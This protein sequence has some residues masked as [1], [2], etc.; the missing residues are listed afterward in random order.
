LALTIFVPSEALAEDFECNGTFAGGTFDNVVVPSG[1]TCILK[2]ATVEGNI[3]V[4]P[5]GALGLEGGIVGGNVESDTARS[6]Y[7]D[8]GL[9]LPG[10]QFGCRSIGVP[11]MIDGNVLIKKTFERPIFDNWICSAKIGGELHL[12]ENEEPF[13]VGD[14]EPTLSTAPGSMWCAPGEA[15]RLEVGGNVKAIKNSHRLDISDVS[16]GQNLQI[17]DNI[18]TAG[19]G[20]T[21]VYSN[22]VGQDLQCDKNAPIQGG[23]NTAENKDGQCAAF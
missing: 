7:I 9:P 15:F 2:G 3:S 20:G 8:C 4:K 1:A 12:E 21:Y 5:T 10:P 13:I 16:V 6:I 19:G 23:G 11:P 18:D 14:A 22:L 17:F